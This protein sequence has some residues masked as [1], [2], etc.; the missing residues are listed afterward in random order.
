MNMYALKNDKGEFF[1]RISH[2]LNPVFEP[3]D[4]EGIIIWVCFSSKIAAKQQKELSSNFNT[5]T[6]IVEFKG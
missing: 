5:E 4:V 3:Y 1:S 6:T 2:S